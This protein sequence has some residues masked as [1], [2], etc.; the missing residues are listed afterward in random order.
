MATAASPYHP[1]FG[2]RPEYLAARDDIL[3]AGRG[4]VDGA[5]L[6]GEM[7]APLVLVGPRGCGKTVLLQEIALH[8]GET[9]G[10]PRLRIEAVH[11]RPLADDLAVRVDEVLASLPAHRNPS[12]LRLDEVVARAGVGAVGAELHFGR[13][14]QASRSLGF[15]QLLRALAEVLQQTDSGLVMTVDETQNMAAADL[16]HLASALQEG[17]EY[18]WPLA[19][20]FAGLAS[21]RDVAR[22][23]TY[24]ER[25]SWH[26]VGFLDVAQSIA[27]LSRPAEAAGKS[28]EPAAAQYLAEHCGGYPYGIQLFGDESWKAAAGSSTVTLH[29]ARTGARAAEALLTSG[30][31]ATRWAQASSREKQYLVAIAEETRQNGRATG[32][33]V[34][35]RLGGSTR[36]WSVHRAR[37]I[38]KGTV[39]ASGGVVHFALPGLIEFILDHADDAA[40]SR[41]RLRSTESAARS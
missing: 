12:G 5:A 22:N 41:A 34:A 25:A 7:P 13:R 23:V 29:H 4:L 16:N 15:A 1:G 2:R 27:A 18:G 11:G 40:S 30:L 38:N 6:P 17:T 36:D 9:A 37:L 28:L 26:E 24:L 21:M 19:V 8:A 20:V 3:A 14:A 33:S 31:Y 39:Y 10:W 32:A 35:A